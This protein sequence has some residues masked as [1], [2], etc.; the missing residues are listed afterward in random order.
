MVTTTNY[1]SDDKKGRI[2]FREFCNQQ[3]SFI[4]NKESKKDFAKWDV[5]YT[6]KGTKF[7]GEIKV[8]DYNATAFGDW[9]LQ[10]DKLEGLRE[11]QK[12]NPDTKISYINIFN[13]NL[14]Y[15]WNLD[16]IDWSNIKQGVL[17]LQKNDYE[18]ELVWKTVYYLPHL[19]AQKFETDLNKTIFTS[20][21]ENDDD[22]DLGF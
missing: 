21:Q 6:Q 17:Q 20:I 18:E 2:I 7:I 12:L 11:L 5:S 3:P 9:F 8:R 1:Q 10:S 15:I 19:L 13:D 4:F 22:L 16:D 14:T